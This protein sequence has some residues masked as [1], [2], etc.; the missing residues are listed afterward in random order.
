MKARDF[1]DRIDAGEDMSAHVDWSKARRPNLAPSP[2]H[3]PQ[4]LIKPQVAHRRGRRRQNDRGEREGPTFGLSPLFCARFPAFSPGLDFS[5]HAP[6]LYSTA[7]RALGRK[8]FALN[9]F[10]GL[11]PT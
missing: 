2:G 10:S 8:P 6:V 9:S 1:D 5:P 4:M 7:R 11:L 3:H